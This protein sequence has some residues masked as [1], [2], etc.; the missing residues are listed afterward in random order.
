ML[1][2]ERHGRERTGVKRLED[3][4]PLFGTDKKPATA[5]RADQ[6]ARVIRMGKGHRWPIYDL[7]EFVGNRC[8]VERLP[9]D[10]D[11]EWLAQNVSFVSASHLTRLF[12]EKLGISPHAFLK[13]VRMDYAAEL[14]KQ[15]ADP[16]ALIACKVGYKSASHFARD[17]LKAFHMNPREF[18]K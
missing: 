4:R 14:L 10:I 12:R 7:Y 9:S 15:T 1:P 16:I 17:F 8:S 11:V 5:I 18:R 6:T 3:R 13:Q 2:A